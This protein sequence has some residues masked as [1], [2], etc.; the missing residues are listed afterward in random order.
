MVELSEIVDK[1]SLKLWCERSFG[2][3]E[4]F[5]DPVAEIGLRAALRVIPLGWL[6]F[7]SKMAL[8]QNLSSLPI[9]RAA[10]SASVAIYSQDASSIAKVG[11]STNAMDK[12]NNSGAHNS[13]RYSAISVTCAAAIFPAKPREAQ[14]TNA[15]SATEAAGISSVNYP[16]G[17]F[18]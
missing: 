12:L 9:L 2:E 17:S 15:Y 10:L 3:T 4:S 14:I 6:S 13:V 5:V 16:I 11:E 8:E 7:E 1:K 18:L